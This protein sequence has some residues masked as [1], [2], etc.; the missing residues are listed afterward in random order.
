M[1]LRRRADD[2]VLDA[3]HVDAD[4][5]VEA[6]DERV[7]RGDDVEPVVELEALDGG[8]DV[9]VGHGVG[10]AAEGVHEPLAVAVG[11]ELAALLAAF[12]GVR[13]LPEVVEH[14]PLAAAEALADDVAALGHGVVDLER[15]L[16]RVR[17]PAHEDRRRDAEVLE[18][19]VEA[20]GGGVVERVVRRAAPADRGLEPALVVELDVAVVVDLDAAHDGDA[21]DLLG[22]EL[23]VVGQRL[24]GV[25]HPAVQDDHE[26]LRLGVAQDLREE[27]AAALDEAVAGRE[28]VRG[29]VLGGLAAV[30][31]RR[32]DGDGGVVVAEGDEGALGEARPLV[33]GLEVRDHAGEPEVAVALEALGEDERV[34]VVEVLAEVAHHHEVQEPL[35]GVGHSSILLQ[36][37]LGS[38]TH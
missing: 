38:E 27:L 10:A 9:L 15:H 23:G 31:H 20:D 5:L 30:E 2:E 6:L 29:L 24:E 3:A 11:G 12:G 13:R 26:A 32:A 22:E 34:L 1:V 28:V 37:R 18:L 19:E 25:G 21:R 33:G 17:G 36:S 14:R 16:A 35:G 4:R 8:P 7:D